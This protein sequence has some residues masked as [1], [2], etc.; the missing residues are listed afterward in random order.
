MKILT[1]IVLC[2]CLLCAVNVYAA[3]EKEDLAKDIVFLQERMA[4]L[5]AEFE[6]ARR[7]LAP[8]E[9]K[10]QDIERKEVAKSQ[11]AAKPAAQK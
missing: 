10:Y 6:L 1:C 11:E 3:S 2:F 7:D 8:L 4:R 5:K 9:Q